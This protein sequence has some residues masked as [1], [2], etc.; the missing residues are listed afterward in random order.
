MTPFRPARWLPGGHTQ[1]LFAPLLRRPPA[2]PRRR[3]RLALEDGDFLDLDWLEQRQPDAPLLI[4]L[5]GLTGSSASSYI[6]GQ[7]QAA[8]ALGWDTLA[9]NWRG[10]SGEPNQ[11]ARSYHSG[12]SEDLAELLAHLRSRWPQRRM[13]AIGFSL[14]GNLLLKYLGEAGEAAALQAAVA[15][16]VPFRLDHSALRIRHGFS[17][18]YQAR[19]MRDLLAYVRTKQRLFEHHGRHAE[20]ARL[21]ALGSLDGLDSLWDFDDRVT[22]PLHGYASAED[23][24]RR[25]SS[26][27]FLPQIRVP[28]LLVQALDDPFVYPQSLPQANE[29]PDCVTFELH[30][31]G[32]HVGFVEGPPWRPAYYLERRLPLWLQKQLC[33]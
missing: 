28:T 5:H 30:A 2:L 29:L 17:R 24:Y 13:A 31:R 7:Q 27:F 11:R 10:C 26:R 32:G 15:V 23:Y 8:A 25:C 18:V 1:T 6:L 19:F 3:Q 9:V 33:H 20:A 4:L 22:A 16:S 12:A 14:G 21:T